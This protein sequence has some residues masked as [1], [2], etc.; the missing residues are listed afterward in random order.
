VSDLAARLPPPQPDPAEEQADVVAQSSG[1]P[2]AGV[3]APDG[4]SSGNPIAAAQDDPAATA[5]ANLDR[6]DAAGTDDIPVPPIPPAV[7]PVAATAPS[8]VTALPLQA[9][10][11]TPRVADSQTDRETARP[12]AGASPSATDEQRVATARVTPAASVEV[13]QAPPGPSNSQASAHSNEHGLPPLQSQGQRDAAGLPP[14]QAQGPIREVAQ[15]PGRA[16][17]QGQGLG[18]GPVPRPVDPRTAENRVNELPREARPPEPQQPRGSTEYGRR[19]Q[20]EAEQ[21]QAGQ[22]QIAPVQGGSLLG[23]SHGS[24]PLPLPAPTPVNAN[25]SG[26]PG[27]PGYGR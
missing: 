9:R 17:A 19:G 27:S 16:A 24:V 23:M 7:I 14:L 3:S 18:R 26:P 21:A 20:M 11:V 22:S 10:P 13:R 5:T 2:P 4:Q 15:G 6:N 8:A 12:R 1:A 25:W